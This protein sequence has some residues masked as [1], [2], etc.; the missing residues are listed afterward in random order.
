MHKGFA[1]AALELFFKNNIFGG[2]GGLN[3]DHRCKTLFYCLHI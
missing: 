3:L 2:E 1:I